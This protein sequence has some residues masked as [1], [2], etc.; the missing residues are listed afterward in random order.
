[1]NL[2]VSAQRQDEAIAKIR[3]VIR[4]L[5]DLEKKFEKE[6]TAANLAEY[7]AGFC[8]A[9]GMITVLKLFHAKVDVED[10]VLQQH[11]VK[12]SVPTLTWG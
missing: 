5:T 10:Y 7:R 8:L 6:P 12:C 3:V 11:R 1:M 4:N 9:D 2:T